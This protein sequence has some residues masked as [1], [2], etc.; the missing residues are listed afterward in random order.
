MYSI[1]LPVRLIDWLIWRNNYY[2]ISSK[3][4]NTF[5]ISICTVI[6]LPLRSNAES[7][8]FISFIILPFPDWW[9][10]NSRSC[11]K[12]ETGVLERLGKLVCDTS[13]K[14]TVN[15]QSINL[16]IVSGYSGAACFQFF[17]CCNFT[18]IFGNITG[19]RDIVWLIDWLMDRQ[20]SVPLL[21]LT[22][23]AKMTDWQKDLMFW[24]A[25]LRVEEG[26]RFT[27]KSLSSVHEGRWI[28][29]L[30]DWLIWSIDWL[31]NWVIEWVS[32]LLIERSIDPLIHWLG[33]FTGQWAPPSDA[34]ELCLQQRKLIK[35]GKAMLVTRT[36]SDKITAASDQPLAALKKRVYSDLRVNVQAKGYYLI[37]RILKTPT[38]YAGLQSLQVWQQVHFVL[39]FCLTLG[40]RLFAHTFPFWW[41]DK[42]KFKKEWFH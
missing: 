13:I 9:Y 15:G 14:Q 35:E 1:K 31:I 24:A 22:L 21:Q 7:Y 29:R 5:L 23:I 2:S 18:K 28:A 25:Q 3:L 33:E 36:T 34:N 42:L 6:L 17:T 26:D 11:S 39:N 41:K 40:A 32:E 12:V 10:R 19:L 8:L 30:I 37:L 27:G 20:D 4:S 16:P 38:Y